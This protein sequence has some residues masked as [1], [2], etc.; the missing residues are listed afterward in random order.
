MEF[1]SAAAS[2]F[3]DWNA[4]RFHLL[5]PS[6]RW[7]PAICRE[8][9]SRWGDRAGSPAVVGCQN[10]KQLQTALASSTSR[11]LLLFFEGIEKHCLAILGRLIDAPTSTPIAAVLRGEHSDLIPVLLESGVT[12]I[13]ME[14]VNDLPMADWCLAV[15][16]TKNPSPE[17]AS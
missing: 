5:D 9:A 16:D 10:S 3:P 11:G 2:L 15:I 8:L 1:E 12:S 14:P 4:R 7:A 6:E 13:I 17:Q